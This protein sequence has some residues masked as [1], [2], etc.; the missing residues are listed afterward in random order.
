[1]VALRCFL[2]VIGLIMFKTCVSTILGGQASIEQDGSRIA[3]VGIMFA[4]ILIL[5]SIFPHQMNKIYEKYLK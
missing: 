1:M 3:F 2:F 4:L 5:T